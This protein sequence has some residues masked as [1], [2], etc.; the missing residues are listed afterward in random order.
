MSIDEQKLNE[1][2][3]RFLNDFGATFHSALA[4][5]GDKLGL[6]KALAEAGPLTSSELAE[7]RARARTARVRWRDASGPLR[8]R[9]FVALRR[10]V[11]VA[12]ID[13]GLGRDRIS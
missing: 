10:G 13:L 6:Y 4:V 11:S 9:R 2:L 3:G 8:T 7:L 1:L 5:I 12:R